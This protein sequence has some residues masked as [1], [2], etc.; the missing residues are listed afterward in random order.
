MKAF[1]NFMNKP[2]KT[3]ITDRDP[4]MCEAISSEMPTTKHS[5]CIWHITSKFS[6]WFVSLL[7]NGYKKWCGDF[8]ESYRMTIPDEFEVKWSLMVEKYNLQTNKHVLGLYGV[9]HFWVPTYLRDYFFGGMITTVRSESINAFIKKFVSSHTC[10]KDFVKQFDLAIQEISHR[11]LHNK[12]IANLRPVPLN[13]KSPLEKQASEVLT[14]FAFKKFQEEFGRATLYTINQVERDVYLVKYFEGDNARQHKV[15]WDGYTMK[16]SC[17]N[18]EFC[19]I[20]CRH[21]FRV[22]IHRDCFNIPS[23]Y[24]PTRW[25]CA[26]LECTH[27]VQEGHD[28]TSFEE[29]CTLTSN[30]LGVGEI[31]LCPPQSKT[32]DRPKN[33][34]EKGGKELGV[35]KRKCCSICKQ[36]GYTKPT[37]PNK[38][39]IFTLNVVDEEISF[40]SSQNNLSSTSNKKQ[41]QTLEDLVLNPIF[42]MK[43]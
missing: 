39:N 26:A 38:E 10:L 19:G 43:I 20:I 32:K 21:A 13:S 16:C 4:W 5:F 15:L 9:K 17:K 25:H 34:R 8:Y 12:V 40:M 29:E 37:C 6:C 22:F 27:D 36:P 2:P 14:P 30:Q 31:V 7:R 24:F 18:F 42:T 28:D 1:V 35:K 23:L 3:I 33:R 41:K 11:H